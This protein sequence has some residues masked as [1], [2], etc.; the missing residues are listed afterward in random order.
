MAF[1]FNP[2]DVMG[3]VEQAVRDNTA[4]AEQHN[5]QFTISHRKDGVRVLGDHDRLMQVLGNLMSNA[6]K[7]SPAGET[8]ELAV[9]QHNNAIRISVTDHGPGIPEAFQ[10]KLFERFTQS[11]ASDTRQKGGTGL[12]L[13]I[14]K[15]I[16]QK[17]GGRI[18]Y[19]TRQGLGTTMFVE[20]PLTRSTGPSQQG[21]IPGH[22]QAEHKPCILI[23]ED[24]PDIANLL[25]QLLS[26]AGYNC[27]I[28][29]TAAEA[30]KLLSLHVEHYKAITLDIKL[31]DTDGV[32]LIEELRSSPL[33]QSLPI[34][35]VSVEADTARRRLNGGAIGIIDWLNKPIDEQRLISALESVCKSGKNPNILHVEDEPDIHH[36]VKSLMAGRATLSW[37]QNLQEAHDM[38]N[39]AHFELILLDIA[40]PDGLGLSLLSEIEQQHPTT[41][42]V[43]YSAYDVAPEYLQQVHAVLSKSNTD[44]DKLLSTIES[45][46]NIN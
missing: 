18:H 42:L 16:V 21:I 33:T 38:L 27:D 4:Y 43:I 2:I 3:L 13:S 8:I 23:I 7:F 24:D 35:V 14:T 9:A 28:A 10:P 20:L 36:I 25:Q 26:G 29:Y 32:A 45:L 34:V 39:K 17:H 40:L 6:A 37:A 31:P 5:V 1:S 30:R 22:L 41:K 11:D 46:L 15:A 19:I 44:N 12:G